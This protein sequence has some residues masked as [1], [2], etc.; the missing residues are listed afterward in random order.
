[1]SAANDERS[2]LRK[3]GDMMSGD[4]EPVRKALMVPRPEPEPVKTRKGKTERVQK[5]LVVSRDRTAV[6]AAPNQ[7]PSI[8]AEQTF[9]LGAGA[10]L[11]RYDPWACAAIYEKS[12]ALRPCMDA[13]AINAHAFGFKLVPVIDL[14]KENAPKMV[15]AA[16]RQSRLAKGDPKPVTKAQVDEQIDV[17]RRQ[18]EIE[19]FDLANF[20]AYCC[21]E[22]SFVAMRMA[23][24]N[25]TEGTGNGYWEVVRD[26]TGK[27]QWVQKVDAVTMRLRPLDQ[28]YI[29]IED[30]QKISPIEYRKRPTP[31][32]FRTFVQLVNGMMAVYFKEFG[33]PRT[34]SA[35]TGH[36]FD[37]P[38]DLRASEGDNA[39]E[40][41]EIIHWKIPA[42][43]G[44]YGV[45]RWVAA[46][47]NI[48][49]L[50][51][52]EEVN[53]THFDEKTIPPYAIIVSGGT[54][55][56]GAV[57]QIK[58][59]LK[60]HK[61]RE[62]YHEAL[63]IEATPPAG[64]PPTARCT[65]LLQ[66]LRDASL[67]DGLFQIYEA[68]SAKKIARQYRLPDLITGMS[69]ETNRAQAEAVLQFVEQQVFQPLREDFDGFI[70]R[71]VLADMGIRFW[72]FQTQSAIATDPKVQ[73]G[74]ICDLVEAGILTPGEGRPTAGD[75][76]NKEF[77]QL[78]DDWTKR[79]LKLS[80]AGVTGGGGV[81][82]QQFA[83]G[84]HD[85]EESAA[86]A[87]KSSSDAVTTR[88]LQVRNIIRSIAG[89]QAQTQLLAARAAKAART[90]KISQEDM[91]NLVAPD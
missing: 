82:A 81:P 10:L 24:C 80:L 27:I 34:L 26:G 8:E 38:A 11:P 54:L 72:T 45:P 6:V 1:M 51:A 49:G 37:S 20:F 13:Y 62:N 63:I 87:E 64:A 43:I 73:T 40:A 59:H 83:P 5:A 41:T 31:R 32:R 85:G 9:F 36:F 57:D 53:Y 61:G 14:E 28:D 33:D 90:I 65:I 76:L 44:P 58:A 50:R 19:E 29:L 4:Y 86:D 79:P 18:A 88:L 17:I 84:A 30:N 21:P 7:K 69:S 12:S 42:I 60:A 70:N 75:I 56:A 15:E 52:A 46:T 77:R 48:L 35:I 23:T 89:D 68:N 55:K 16:L 25:D 47:M 67:Q 91:D 71:R 74:I 78:P 22:Q 66:S 2:E 39:K 3:L